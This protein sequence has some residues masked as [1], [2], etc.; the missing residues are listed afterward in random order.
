MRKLSLVGLLVVL[1]LP[2]CGG[3]SSSPA[4]PA[5]TPAP[6][7]TPVSFSGSYSGPMIENVAGLGVI[8]VIGTTAVTHSGGTLTFGNLVV[9]SVGFPT[10]TYQLGTAALSANNT[11]TG[12]SFYQSNGC[13]QINVTWTCTLG[14]R[15]STTVMNLAVTLTSVTPNRS[16]CQPF[17]FRGEITK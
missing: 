13:D 6:T 9:T 15:G 17:E 3:S 16:G 5:P 10:Q 12:A 11:C 2:A 8:N 14:F 1:S 4:A 7:P